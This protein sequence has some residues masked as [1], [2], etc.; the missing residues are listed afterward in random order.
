M[1]WGK[2]LYDDFTMLRCI[3]I[4]FTC[5]WDDT[6]RDATS[7]RQWD[8]ASM[9]LYLL[10]MRWGWV[11]FP[12]VYDVLLVWYQ[13]T[14][15]KPLGAN[16]WYGTYVNTYWVL[17]REVETHSRCLLV[18]QTTS[19]RLELL[20]CSCYSDHHDVINSGLCDWESLWCCGL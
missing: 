6:S 14:A 9:V 10:A 20:R 12:D 8:D 11:Y 15:S 4:V 5:R 7:T 17:I 3:M 13:L 1:R 18:L 2:L 16:V 19:N